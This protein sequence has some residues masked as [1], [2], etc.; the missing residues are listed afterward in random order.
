[1]STEYI[2]FVNT[3]SDS[4]I[5][6]KIYPDA[7]IMRV[8]LE[9]L[10]KT[11]PNLP[12]TAHLWIDP[13]IDGL[14]HKNLDNLSENY[15][16]HIRRFPGYREIAGAQF[17][18]SPDKKVVEQFVFAVLDN[19]LQQNPAWL[20]V[21]QLP[22]ATGP[23]RNKINKLLAEQ[24]NLWKQKSSFGGKLILP[25]IFTHQHQISK[26]TERNKKIASIVT[27]LKAA[28]AYG[29]WAVD[30]S[31]ND[32]EGSGTFDDRFP[33]LRSFHE[34]LLNALP[35]GIVTVCGPYWGMNLV[36][37]ARNLV[38]FPGI[39]LGSSYKYNV[40][41]AKL[42]TAKARIALPS[43]R[44]WAVARPPLKTWLSHSVAQLGPS[45][46]V[47]AEFAGLEREFSKLQETTFAKSQVAK[48]YNSWFHKFESLPQR[49]RALALYQDLSSAYVLGKALGKLPPDELTGRR[50][51]RVAQQ[52]MMNCL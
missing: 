41:G 47:A 5:A 14:H 51:E 1:M 46:P 40:P 39:G 50:P 25:A 19:C 16:A 44:R 52:L 31:L 4:H 23:G 26:K 43:L 30:S 17:Q 3:T 45:D 18:L 10:A 15:T 6:A 37:W 22:I 13:A 20:S 29:I 35:S 2:P 21:P 48:F 34:E 8:S 11:R 7:M 42:P 9:T 24:T 49:G 12:T 38:A 32:Q 36:L 27:C 33:A 28:D